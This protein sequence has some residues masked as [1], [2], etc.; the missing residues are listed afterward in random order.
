MI[1]EIFDNTFKSKICDDILRSLP[2]WFGIEESIVD[3][4]NSVSNMP[5]Y[6]CFDGDSPVGFLAIKVHNRYTAEVCVMGIIKDYHRRSIGRDL[7]KSC[8]RFCKDK[9]IDFLTVKTLDESREDKNYAKTRLFYEAMGFKPL[10]VFKTL[11]DEHNPCLF[12]VKHL[13]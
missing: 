3:Y 6:V 10:E 5:F 1:K 4:V 7:I 2:D 8:E 9:N 11:W 12:M 13:I